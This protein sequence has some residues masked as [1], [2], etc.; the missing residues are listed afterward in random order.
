MGERNGPYDNQL[1]TKNNNFPL[2]GIIEM[3]KRDKI[4][5]N[6]GKQEQIQTQFL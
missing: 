2:P 1:F 6:L 5:D 3:P 4:V